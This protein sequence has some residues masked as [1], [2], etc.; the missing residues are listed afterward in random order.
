MFNPLII[1]TAELL[2][3]RHG[4]V[5]FDTWCELYPFAIQS[6]ETH[7]YS[8]TSLVEIQQTLASIVDGHNRSLLINTSK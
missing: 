4:V 2:Q 8:S 1:P 7:L 3:P 6:G 5:S